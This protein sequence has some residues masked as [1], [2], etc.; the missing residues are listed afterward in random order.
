MDAKQIF[1]CPA[2]P[3]GDRGRA[4][5]GS[6][7]ENGDNSAKSEGPVDTFMTSTIKSAIVRIMES[8]SPPGYEGF[9][10]GWQARSVPV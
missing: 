9:T 10:A 5:M 3:I 1:D 4:I 6:L 7:E 8:F 2:S